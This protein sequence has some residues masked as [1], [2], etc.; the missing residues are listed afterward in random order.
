MFLHTNL[1]F[2]QFLTYNQTK[3]TPTTQKANHTSQEAR[4][5]TKY[6]IYEYI[7]YFYFDI[8]DISNTF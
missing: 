8:F 1:P 5:A 2:Y 6:S 7:R 4:V 3:R